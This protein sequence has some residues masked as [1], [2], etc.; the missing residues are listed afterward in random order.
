MGASVNEDIPI[1]IVYQVLLVPKRK[2]DLSSTLNMSLRVPRED[3][4]GANFLNIPDA[5]CKP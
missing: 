1:H 2:K 5:C 4:F 3:A